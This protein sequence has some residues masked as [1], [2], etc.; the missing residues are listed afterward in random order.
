[1]KKRPRKKTKRKKNHENKNQ[2]LY[3]A[4]IFQVFC[5]LYNK[6]QKLMSQLINQKITNK[7]FVSRIEYKYKL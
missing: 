2:I 6:E 7:Y 5:L 3:F 4:I 1:M